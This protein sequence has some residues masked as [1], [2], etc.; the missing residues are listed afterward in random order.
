MRL[1]VANNDKFIADQYRNRPNGRNI[2]SRQ[3]QTT[4]PAE[5]NQ[6]TSTG[7]VSSPNW[8]LHAGPLPQPNIPIANADGRCCCRVMHDGSSSQ[9]DSTACLLGG[10]EG[11]REGWREGGREGRTDGRRDEGEGKEGRRAEGASDRGGRREGASE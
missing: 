7:R 1:D 5:P 4:V 9:R 2:T 10:M 3:W 11:W 6:G 8:R